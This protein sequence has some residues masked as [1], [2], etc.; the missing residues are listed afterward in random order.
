MQMVLVSQICGTWF[1]LWQSD[2]LADDAYSSA[3]IYIVWLYTIIL[4]AA[5]SRDPFIA[6]DI[7]AGFFVVLR[8]RT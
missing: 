2:N 4:L 7:T 8:A 5:V 6:L 1:V 3:F